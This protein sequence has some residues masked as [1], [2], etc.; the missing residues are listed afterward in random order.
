MPCSTGSS[1]TSRRESG[2]LP[3]GHAPAG[4][5]KVDDNY[6]ADLQAA[7]EAD[8]RTLGQPFSVWSC[9]DLAQY[10]S[11]K[12]YPAVHPETVRRHLWRLDFRLVRPVTCI[13]S[14]DPDYADKAA[15]LARYQEQARRGEIVLLYEDEVDLNLLPGVIGCWTRRGSQRKVPTPGKN[16]K[17][18]GFGTVDFMTGRLVRRIEERKRSDGFIALVE[19]V[20]ATYCPGEV[21]LG[22][23]VVLVV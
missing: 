17:R 2:A 10:Q 14:P 6:Q 20:V 22:R 5:P 16:E 4:P 11:H 21:W 18:Y 19:Q 13:A 9:Q 7:V 1:A 3:S 15:E 8:P 23:K 12:G